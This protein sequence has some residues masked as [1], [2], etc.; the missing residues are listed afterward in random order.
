MAARLK[1]AS[2]A[3]NPASGLGVSNMF[4][5]FDKTASPVKCTM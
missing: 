4:E 1:K 2:L 5:M 3:L